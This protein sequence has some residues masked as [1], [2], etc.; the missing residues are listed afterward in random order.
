MPRYARPANS[1]HSEDPIRAIGNMVRAGIIGYLREHPNSTKA[2]IARDLDIP[3]NTI[4]KSLSS[5]VETN[6]LIADPPR[7][8]ALRGQRVRYRVDDA[9][10]SEMYL[11]L[12]QAI[13]EV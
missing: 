9:A 4:V 3:T 5:L 12:G 8:S 11:Q 10:V 13:G 1:E 7:E 2:D 6:L